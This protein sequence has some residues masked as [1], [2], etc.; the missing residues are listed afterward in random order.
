MFWQI[1]F[2]ENRVEVGK[3]DSLQG[4]RILQGRP[5]AGI[6]LAEEARQ[7]PGLEVI[8]CRVRSSGALEDTPAVCL[9]ILAV[10]TGEERF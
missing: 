6:D 4:L 8:V 3:G 10:G 2:D 7:I 5:V 9:E 1:A